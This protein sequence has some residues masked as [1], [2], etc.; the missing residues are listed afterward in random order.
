MDLTVTPRGDATIDVRFDAEVCYIRFARP[1]AGNTITHALIDDVGHALRLCETQA[2]IV[3]LEGSPQA[4]CLGADF[5]GIRQELEAGRQFPDQ[6]PAPLYDLWQ[7]LARGP[8]VS[9]AHV[10]GKA[11]AGGVGFVAACDIV[12]CD[13]TAVF[14]LS[15]ML[16]GLMP[17]CVLPFLIRR[18]GF[19]RANLLTLGT[20]TLS[21][22]QAEQWG[23]VDA[24]EEN[25]ENLL[26]KHLLRLK[27]L[28]KPAIARYKRYAG[29]LDGF[30][31]A[32]RP[33]ALQ[34]NIDVFS[35]PVNLENIRRYVSTGRFPWDA[36]L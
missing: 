17:A 33:A 4:F 2:R 5:A 26:R 22:R 35:D 13:E 29:E 18:V 11:N 15:E 34:A 21:A 1:E 31:S 6:D 23:L 3:V 24:C 19:A 7:K 9:I 16:F 28:T 25:G 14:S 10:R 27:R 8:F 30:F 36:G 32:A 20:Q 12:L